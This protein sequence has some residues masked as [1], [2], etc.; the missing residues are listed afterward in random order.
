VSSVHGECRIGREQRG[1]DGRSHGPGD[2]NSA[3]EEE[4]GV[5]RFLARPRLRL[6]TARNDNEVGRIKIRSDHH[7]NDY[8]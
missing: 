7:D 2:E 5:S 6:R 4:V 1:I 3:A 8:K